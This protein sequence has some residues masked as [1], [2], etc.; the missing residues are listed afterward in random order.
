MLRAAAIMQSRKEELTD[1]LVR[2]PGSTRLKAELEWEFVHAIT[3]EAALF[4][5]RAEGRILPRDDLGKGLSGKRVAVDSPRCAL[6]LS[7]GP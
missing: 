7:I 4:P 3:L 6:G 5:H 1:W 2:E